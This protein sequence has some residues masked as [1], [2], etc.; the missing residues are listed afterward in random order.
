MKLLLYAC[1]IVFA[2]LTMVCVATGQGKDEAK[3]DLDRMQGSWRVV[4][5][6]MA[7]VKAT[8][9]EVKKMKVIVDYAG[10]SLE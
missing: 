6:Q 2:S 5:S 9:N 1:A 8:E 10:I 3:T 4:S 7:D